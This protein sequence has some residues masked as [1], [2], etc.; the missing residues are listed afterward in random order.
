MKGRR[1][2]NDNDVMER[3]CFR[4]NGYLKFLFADREREREGLGRITGQCL[5]LLVTIISATSRLVVER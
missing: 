4:Y 2:N 5:Y 1:E 3:I